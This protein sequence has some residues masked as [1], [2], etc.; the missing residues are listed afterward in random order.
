MKREYLGAALVL[1]ALV[2]GC[3]QV[4]D[5]PRA[6]DPASKRPTMF[7]E[8]V[9]FGDAQETHAWLGVPFA[10]PP[11]DKLR[12][13]A[14]VPPAAWN[15]VRNALKFGP[16]CV[17]Y[18]SVFGG[19]KDARP[20][21]PVG[22]EDCLYL[23]I[24]A[25]RFAPDQVPSGK[26]RLPVMFWIHGGG[27]TIGTASFYD[28]SNLAGSQKVLVV[29][30]QY[31][32]G[33]FGWF[34]HPSLNDAT[35]TDEERSGNFGTLDLIRSLEWVRK[36]IA[37]FGGDPDN[38]TIFG[39]SAGGTNVFSLLLSPKAH[40]LF[41]RAIVESG[42]TFFSTPQRAEA[43]IDDDPPGD[44]NSSSELLL[45]LVQGDK[46]AKDRDG[47]KVHLS[48]VQPG[49]V[50]RYLRGKSA[51]EILSGYTPQP[52]VGMIRMPLLFTEGLVLPQEDPLERMQR[53]G[54]YNQ[55][56]VMLGTNRDENKLFM[57]P[58][59]QY[60]RK[61]LWIFPRLR[62]AQQY[63]LTAE[64]LAKNWKATGVDE[65][66][67]A[68]RAVQGAS[69]FAYRFDWDEE[70]M[71]LGSNLAEMLGASHGFEIQFVFGHFDLGKEGNRIFTKENEAGRLALSQ[72]M[73]S[74]W[75][76][77]AYHGAPGRGRDSKLPEWTAWDSSAA[78]APKF[79]VLDTDSGGGVRMSSESV[80][81]ASLLDTLK[82]DPRLGVHKDK[83]KLYHELAAWSR[84]I[85][86]TDFEKECA[87]LPFDKFPWDA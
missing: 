9:G 63:N 46:I 80:T 13:R 2:A 61:F 15:N 68:M 34:R 57:F 40:G 35:T 38:I 22:N 16:P 70:P 73:M 1:V 87:D 37:S 7:G 25:P 85:S 3:Q 75:A 39:E 26:A 67:A 77:F 84:G 30:T 45:R 33:P 78:A 12:W 5:V 32:L 20:G 6:A 21:T 74:Y 36:N 18:A 8:V 50:S 81:R 64:Y 49:D 14:P 11:I 56:P 23:N 44:P 29:T 58:S 62:D 51:Y 31:R 79:M 69:V 28:G 47:A 52:N 71:L 19:V 86:K 53:P 48:Y 4:Q 66:A 24:W 17:Q 59:P 41:Q 72:T 60:V 82:K 55:V 65:P 27:N 54:G 10:A 43:S 83:C 76:E 42:G